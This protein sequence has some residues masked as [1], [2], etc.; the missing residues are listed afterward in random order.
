MTDTNKTTQS[1][2]LKT[3]ASLKDV[4]WSTLQT[5]AQQLKD[6]N[7]R[8]ASIQFKLDGC[9]AEVVLVNPNKKD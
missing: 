7:A 2:E 6:R 3:D 9:D 8:S 1:F 5:A 4:I